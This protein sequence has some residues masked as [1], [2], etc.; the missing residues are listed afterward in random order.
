MRISALAFMV[1]EVMCWERRVWV[2][3]RVMALK[4]SSSEIF[5]PVQRKRE[6]R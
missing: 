6:H 1:G 4:N 3:V 2:V 5:T